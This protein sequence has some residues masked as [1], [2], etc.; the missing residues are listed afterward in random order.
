M[1]LLWALR[2]LEPVVVA[3]SAVC[4]ELSHQGLELPFLLGVTQPV[5]LAVFDL[6]HD[7]AGL[8]LFERLCVT[9][10]SGKNTVEQVL[11]IRGGD[12]LNDFLD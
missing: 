3:L 2:H 6:P 9:P 8:D 1:A 7:H 10:L 5:E 12:F 11:I 4:P